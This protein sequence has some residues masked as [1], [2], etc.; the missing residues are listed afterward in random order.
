MDVQWQHDRMQDDN[1]LNVERRTSGCKTE[2]SLDKD[3]S[4]M[5]ESLTD[6]NETDKSL[7]TKVQ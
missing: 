1:T 3:G 7:W 5:D 2:L 6:E 4:P